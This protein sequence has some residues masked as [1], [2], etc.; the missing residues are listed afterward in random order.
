MM[1]QERAYFAKKGL[2]PH[3][4]PKRENKL[5]RNEHTRA[6]SSVSIIVMWKPLLQK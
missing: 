1:L 3:Y 2:R 4:G 5:W 6:K